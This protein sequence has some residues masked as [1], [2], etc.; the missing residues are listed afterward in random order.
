MGTTADEMESE[1]EAMA[2][3]MITPA[4]AIPTVGKAKVSVGV[5]GG[6]DVLSSPLVTSIQSIVQQT[7]IPLIEMTRTMIKT[8]KARRVLMR[9]AAAETVFTIPE[10]RHLID[11][12]RKR[13]AQLL[14]SV[15]EMT[16]TTVLMRLAQLRVPMTPLMIG[17]WLQSVLPKWSKL[18]SG[19]HSTAARLV[20]LIK[21]ATQY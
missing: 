9:E 1:R 19:N 6:R 11:R 5:I 13:A 16:A 17:Q 21:S 3:P 4:N 18:W 7:E 20:L 15:L 14:E 12:G 8:Q 2:G 10:G